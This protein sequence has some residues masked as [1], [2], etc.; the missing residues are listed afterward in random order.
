MALLECLGVL[1]GAKSGA[2]MM[3]KRRP[4]NDAQNGSVPTSRWSKKGAVGTPSFVP[5]TEEF[6]ADADLF[7]MGL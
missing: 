1:L 6:A 7:R 4:N 2:N 3:P 5:E